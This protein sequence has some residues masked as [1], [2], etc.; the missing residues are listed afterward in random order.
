MANLNKQIILRYYLREV[1]PRHY[2]YQVFE[3]DGEQTIGWSFCSP[4]HDLPEPTDEEM[5]AMEADALAWIETQGRMISYYD[6]WDLLSLPL[7]VAVSNYAQKQKMLP[8][9]DMELSVILAKASDISNV[10]DLSS[11][12]VSGE[13]GYMK[14]ILG[15]LVA[16]GVLT[17]EQAGFQVLL[18]GL[19]IVPGHCHQQKYQ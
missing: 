17:A 12:S 4:E 13:T 3:E 18:P 14:T 19:A 1:D 8:E 10:I 2:S 9:P 16:A 5:E 6:F 7:Q 11:E 15:K